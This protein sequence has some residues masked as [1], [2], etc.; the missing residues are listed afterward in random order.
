MSK[1]QPPSFKTV[2]VVWQGRTFLASILYIYRFDT[3]AAQNLTY[4]FFREIASCKTLL[5]EGGK[6]FF[7]KKGDFYNAGYFCLSCLNSLVLSDQCECNLYSAR[8]FIVDQ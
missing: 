4:S 6:T 3:C 8:I 5:R 2:A 1:F 7:S